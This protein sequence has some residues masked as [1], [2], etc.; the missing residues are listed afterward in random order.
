MNVLVTGGAGFIGSFV[1]QDLLRRG[2]SVVSIDNLN[3]YYDPTLKMARL[4]LFE[5]K[6]SSYQIDIADTREVEEIFKTHSFD[7]VCHLA[8]QA[9]VRYSIEDPFT[10]AQSNY[11]GTLNIFEFSKR[12]N[13]PQIVAASSSSVYGLNNEMPFNETHRVDTPAS[14]YAATKRGTELLAHTYHHLFGLNIAMLR[15]FTVYGPWGRPDMAPFIFT[16]AILSGETIKVFNNGD[17]SRDFTYIDDIVSGIVSALERPNGFAVYNLGRGEPV[18]LMDFIN[19]VEEV[20]G[21]KAILDFQ[22][23]QPGDV[24]A[25]WADIEKARRELNY[26][27]QTSVRAGMAAFVNWYREYYKT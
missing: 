19:A 14:T 27:P 9:G 6:I 7:A 12:Y 1:I 26:Q 10:Y 18:Q 4:K 5:D 21:K 17:M 8:A 25:T 13:V 15:F 3:D 20:S 24:P 11:I 2:H 16:K 23:M 22:P